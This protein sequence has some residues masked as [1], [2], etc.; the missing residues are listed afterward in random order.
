MPKISFRSNFWE[1]FIK[2]RQLRP[3]QA[4][5]YRSLPLGMTVVVFAMVFIG[6]FSAIVLIW[7]QLEQQVQLRVLSAQSSTQ[8]LYAAERRNILQLVQLVSERPTL[9]ALL[10]NPD[11]PKLTSYLE[12]LQAH[13]TADALVVIT[14]NGQKIAS[15]S[16]EVPSGA[17]LEPPELP[18]ADFVVLENPTRLAI[19]GISEIASAESCG[20]EVTGRVI[21]LHVF[22]HD[23]MQVLAKDTGLEQSL[24]IGDRRVVTSFANLMNWPL[25]PDAVVQVLRTQEA[26]CTMG[27]SGDETYYVGLAPLLDGQGHAIALSE[28]ALSAST[29]RNDTLK[30]IALILGISVLAGLAGGALTLPLSRRITDP[31]YRLSDA[32]ERMSLGDLE[33]PIPISSG[34]I[35]ID[36][37]ASQLDH[38]RRNLRQIQRINRRELTRIVH[39]LGATREG[40]ITI[41]VE[42]R[43]TWANADACQI[44]GY[45]ILDL[46]RKHYLQ[47]FRPAPG[48]VVT[49]SDILQPSLGRPLPDRLTILNAQ[50]ASITLT[51][52]HSVLDIENED[53]RNSHHE[54]V[55]ILR[56]VSEEQAIN[57]LRSEFLANVAHEF[58]T[59]LSVIS[60]STELLVDEGHSMNSEEFSHLAHTIHLSTVHLQTLVNNLL[61][62]AIIDA[63]VFRLRR[64]PVLLPD[65]L[66]NL[67]EMISP[68]LQQRQQR[69]EVDAP[70]ELS[71][72][73]G[74]P[75]RLNQAL[76]NLIENASKFSSP[77]AAI[78]L[79]VKCGKDAI[80][81]AALDSGPGL[82]TERFSDLFNRFVT[83]DR[84]LGGH[85]GIGL[86][87]PIVK[88]IAEAHGGRVGAE[89]RPEGGAMVWFTIP[90]K[91]Q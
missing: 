10:E 38:A 77:A 8:A 19:V 68:L 83:E 11:V 26:C 89:N 35:T 80:T 36:R 16:M 56:D 12:V 29:I 55:L 42:G 58:R 40:V 88:A 17:F 74:D 62:S 52:S 85:Y 3:R 45:D 33:T 57:R 13:T 49:L 61:E 18:F 41:N 4:S 39:L 78:G 28:V 66:E 31:L 67:V 60:A 71:Y 81:F 91:Q 22:D 86:V 43:V 6:G 59:P 51:V 24:I 1:T 48:E 32:A 7:R 2:A 34:W 14:S 50:D 90:L 87:L 69:L 46:L 25:N 76:V 53:V 63:G 20:N 72:F 9:C 82:P 47:V 30:T 73:W 15:T 65:F 75:D 54:H 44:L 5:I 27:K 37:L 64:R 21:A 70:E 84:P 23:S 79:S